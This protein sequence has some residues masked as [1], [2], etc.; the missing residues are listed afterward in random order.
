M[1]IGRCRRAYCRGMV[2]DKWIRDPARANVVGISGQ[3]REFLSTFAN[4]SASS[5][6]ERKNT[7]Q[8]FLSRDE[9]LNYANLKNTRM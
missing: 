7:R 8:D 4:N 2:V 5:S 9:I 1:L 3:L 6:L